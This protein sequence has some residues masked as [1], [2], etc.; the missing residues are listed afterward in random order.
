M[1][2]VF[3][4]KSLLQRRVL[5]GIIG[6]VVAVAVTITLV[7]TLVVIPNQRAAEA[8]A[9]AASASAAAEAQAEQDHQDAVDAFSSAATACAN[10]NNTLASAITNAQ[11]TAKTDPKTMQDPSLIDQLNQAIATAQAVTPCTSPTMAAD[12]ATIQQQTTQLDTD[13]QLV[14]AAT[15]ALNSAAQAVPASVKA[16]TDA[17]AAAEAAAQA[18]KQAKVTQL[19]N[20]DTE[21]LSDTNGY[22]AAVTLSCTNWIKGSDTAALSTAWANSGGTGDVP[23]Q[24]GAYTTDANITH[25]TDTTMGAYVFCKF[26]MKNAS[27]GYSLSQWGG[28]YPSVTISVDYV[29]GSVSAGHPVGVAYIGYS[30]PQYQLF[31]DAVSL[32]VR[33]SI[34]GDTWGPIPLALYVNDAFSPKSPNGDPTLDSL[35]LRLIGPVG[36]DTRSHI[37]IGLS[38]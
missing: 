10:A 20:T 15:S 23:V 24:D 29:K 14:E 13:R 12:T 9:A 7:V 18:A 17:E 27:P 38:W 5:I 36:G 28:A 1:A 32:G 11:E 16:K 33:P 3:N 8:A 6:G 4:L 35:T 26:G 2:G 34:T 19:G 37:S 25:V 30:S 21:T 31:H 22:K